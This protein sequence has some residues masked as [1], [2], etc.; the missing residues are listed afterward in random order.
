ML[1]FSKQL[2]TLHY[3]KELMDSIFAEMAENTVTLKTGLAMPLV[4]LGT[5]K[6]KPGEVKTAVYEALKIGYRHIDCAWRHKNQTEVG[7]ALAQAFEE[8]IVKREDLWITSKL[9]ND[10]HAEADVEPHLQDTLNQLQ[11]TYLDLYLVHY[12]ATTIEAPT[13]TPPYSETWAAMEAVLMKGLVHSIGV[14]NM[15]IKKLEEMKEYASVP[16]VVCQGEMHPLFRQDDLFKYCESEGIHWTAYAP[17]GSRDSAE[18][19]N[20]IGYT[21]LQNET[22]V[23]IADEVKKTPAQVLIRWALQHGTS[24]IPKSVCIEHIRENFEVF[25]WEL[26]VEQ[27]QALSTLEP[28]ARFL[29]GDF[30]LMPG[31]P[32]KSV[33]IFW[34]EI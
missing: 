28:Q 20:H 2:D 34:D 16:P 26:S 29:L 15:S 31:G 9:W 12:P 33:A 30:L 19:M 32:Y 7:E 6:S 10:F 21:L 17:L 27:Y 4:G 14:S 23:K 25:D 13:L 1:K 24:V 22:V 3:T 8:G 18:S 5:W 11:L